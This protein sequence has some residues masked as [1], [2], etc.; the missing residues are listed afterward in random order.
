MFPDTRQWE[1]IWLLAFIQ[2]TCKFRHCAPLLIWT[3]IVFVSCE[4]IATSRL[5]GVFQSGGQESTLHDRSD[6]RWKVHHHRRA[7]S[8]QNAE[9]LGWLPQQG[10]GKKT[11]L[12]HQCKV[13]ADFWKAWDKRKNFAQTECQI[14]DK[15]VIAV[16]GLSKHWRLTLKETLHSNLTRC[17]WRLWAQK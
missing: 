4:E 2:V 1:Q 12:A 15:N 8:A 11:L 9:G 16:G 5:L 13:S 14:Q 17:T 6:S 3:C 7:Q 10:N